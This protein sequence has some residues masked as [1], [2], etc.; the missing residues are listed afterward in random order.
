M[1]GDDLPFGPLDERMGKCCLPCSWRILKIL[2][3]A[4]RGEGIIIPF[5]GEEGKT[6]PG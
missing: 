6:Q 5:H 3:V 4:S 1:E 2:P